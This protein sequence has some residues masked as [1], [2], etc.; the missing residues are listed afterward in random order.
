MKTMEKF[1]FFD[2]TKNDDRE[3]AEKCFGGAGHWSKNYPI[4]H[5]YYK[6]AVAGNTAN[7][8]NTGYTDGAV[9]FDFA[10]NADKTISCNGVTVLQAP[11]SALHTILEVY[12]NSEL[13]ARD[14]K[15]LSN[16][17]SCKL[18][19]AAASRE[20]H[21]GDN[22]HAQLTCFYNAGN[23]LKGGYVKREL[24]MEDGRYVAGVK[25]QN[26][27]AKKDFTAKEIRVAYGRQPAVGEYVD[28][29]R[30]EERDPDGNE[31]VSLEMDGVVTLSPGCTF[32]E[33]LDHSAAMFSV[34]RGVIVYG[35][36]PPELRQTDDG[37]SWSFNTNWED[38]IAKSVQFGDA[39]FDYDMKIDFM[40]KDAAN[41]ETRQ[42]VEVT[43]YSNL[44]ALTNI[45]F[46]P[47]LRLLWGCIAKGERVPMADGGEKPVEELKPG[48]EVKTPGGS[49]KVLDIYSGHEN[50]ITLIQTEDGKQIKLTS[51]HPILTEAGFKRPYDL[52]N[53]KILLADG[54]K[55]TVL[56]I[57]P[58]P[59]N[60]KVY[61]VSLEGSDAFFCSG[62]ISGTFD[63][64]NKT[65][66][67]EKPLASV[68]AALQEEIT[69]IEKDAAG[70]IIFNRISK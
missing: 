42:S 36:N 54:S 20:I 70:A 53:N 69:R 21:S 27:R 50:E 12:C 7:D 14:V 47:P 55:T 18:V 13:I 30:P 34:E 35:G 62:F 5:G 41:K 6:N 46:I 23:V 60:D 31:M 51:N 32:S 67:G 9:I 44:T 4:S 37:F 38:V 33:Y 24:S 16:A 15:T 66:P 1:T 11:S 64:Q 59:Y 45:A 26:P 43:S 56:H 49:T 40:C 28:Y 57:H 2:F 25:C 29:V 22:V 39:L 8:E 10:G 17:Q 68:P 63:M 48:D 3:Y 61:G 19:C 65:L 58:V 52:L